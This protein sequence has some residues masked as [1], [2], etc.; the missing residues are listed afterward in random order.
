MIIARKKALESVCVEL[1]QAAF[2]DFERAR[3]LLDTLAAVD[4]PDI[5]YPIRLTYHRMGA[6]LENQWHHYER[7]LAHLE[8]VVAICER[9]TDPNGLADAAIDAAAVH[10]NM[11]QWAKAQDSLDKARHHLTAH[12]NPRLSAHLAGREG[13]LYLHLG[14]LRLALQ[15]L[16]EAE[17]GLKNLNAL[18]KLK[19]YYLLSLVLSGLGELYLKLDEEEKSLRAYLEVLPLVEIH[20]LRPRLPWH[21]LNAGRTALAR[22][23][24]TQAYRCFQRVLHI[25]EADDPEVRAL[26][27]ANMGILSFLENRPEEA[28]RLYDEAANQFIPHTK[29]ADFTNL[30]KIERHR[31]ELQS[32]QNELSMAAQ[33]LE[34]AYAYGEKGTDAQH[35]GQI[36]Q[37]L[38]GIHAELGNY[39]DAYRWQ[40]RAGELQAFHLQSV[41]DSEREELEARHQLESIR[42]EA[43]LAKLMVTGLQARALR[44]QMNPHFLFNALNAIQGLISSA[45]NEEAVSYLAKFALLMRQTLDYSEKE[46]VDLEQE[47]DFLERYLDINNR[48]RFRGRLEFSFHTPDLLDTSEL[49]IPT[50]ILQPFVENAIEH[51]LKSREKGTLRISFSLSVHANTLEAVLEDDGV[52]YNRGRE[53]QLQHQPF[54]T[55]HRSRGM[56]ITRERLRL[57]HSLQKNT[58]K[59]HI[60]IFDRSD[61][62]EGRETGTRVEVLLPLLEPE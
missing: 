60:R 54:Y 57:L 30:S 50:M 27:L 32:Q 12:P 9:L 29:P 28:M 43:Q 56:D 53:E 38:G 41:R 59:E 45:K 61:Y 34:K 49:Y 13:F 11:R 37:L 8:S 51:G 24:N 3:A 18:A 47:I 39:A 55:E 44:A 6:F 42:R 20:N 17:K 23:D 31:A 48:L 2:T 22:S 35:L 26:A 14:N 19:D 52:G 1:E 10:L 36:C 58:T 4:A 16:L 40:F 7:S 5:P 33:T 62:S 46:V 15:N 25:A 21:Y